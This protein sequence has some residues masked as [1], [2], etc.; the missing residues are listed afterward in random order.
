M[1]KISVVMP[2]YNAERFLELS[3]RSVL[4]Q[5]FKDFEL[6]LVDDCSTDGTLAVAESFD[7]ARIK[8]LRNEKNLGTP[9]AARNVGFDA[10]QGEYVYFMDDDDVL[11]E[12][13]LE[14]L[15]NAAVKNSADAVNATKWYESQNL[16]APNAD[17]IKLELQEMQNSTV[18][19]DLQTR[20]YQEFL[21]GG[22]HIAPWLFLYR[23]E[24]LLANGI[25]FP[26]A[27]AEDVFFNFDV[28]CATGKIFKVSEPFYIWR[29]YKGSTTQ[30]PARLAKNLQSILALH[31]HI[32]EKL[33]PLGD[34]EF[35]ADVLRFWTWHTLRSYVLPILQRKSQAEISQALAPDFA[36]NAPF[37]ATLLQLYSQK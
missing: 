15:F 1:A 3:V 30:N 33:S 17:E 11:L 9:G 10:A 6:I 29:A 21:R 31:K 18:S 24:F 34:A 35:T 27:A 19:A 32:L 20:L 37:V 36:Q 23:R 2:L 13:G 14:I 5:T 22:M 8:I 12:R 7:D 25:K 16:D 4:E 26:A 28:L